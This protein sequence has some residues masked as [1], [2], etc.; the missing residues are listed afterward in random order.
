MVNANKSEI[1]LACEIV[2]LLD[3]IAITDAQN[4]LARAQQLLLKT[5]VVNAASPL[6]AVTD[7]TDAALDR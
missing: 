3:G 2:R 7:E 1:Q 4:A 6:L 5:Q